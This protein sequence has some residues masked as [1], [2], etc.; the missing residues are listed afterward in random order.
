M[1][2]LTHLN[3][4]QNE[5]Q[6]AVLH[7][8][9]VAPENPVVG[10]VYFNTEDKQA[11]IYQ[12]TGWENLGLSNELLAKL[13]GIEAGADKV[14]YGTLPTANAENAGKVIIYTGTE[15]ETHKPGLVYICEE[16]D[17]A[18]AWVEATPTIVGGD[19]DTATVTVENGTVSV[20]VKVVR[21]ENNALTVK[22]LDD[23]TTTLY[24]EATEFGEATESEPGMMSAEDKAKLDEIEEKAQVNVLEGVK[25][26]GTALT[27]D[28]EKNVDV[29]IEAKD[30]S[31]EIA[32]AE[33]KVT[34]GV[35]VSKAE[36]NVLTLAEDGLSVI[37]PD[38]P[39][40]S[41]VKAETAEAGYIATYHL[42]K[43][44]ENIGASINIPKDFLVK[45]ADL[46]EVTVEGQP[47]AEAK[48]GDKYIDFVVNVKAG[49]EEAASHIYL[50]VN[51]LVDV[52]TAGNGIEISDANVVSAKV[53]AENG[54]SV[55]ENGIKL[56]M[57]SADAA[58]AMSKEH[59]A[60]LEAIEAQAQV[61]KLE[62][63]QFNGADLAIDENKKVNVV[64][65]EA[66]EEAAGF[67]SATDKA[68]LNK[69]ADEAE[70]NVLEGVKLNNV[71]IEIDAD[72]K[73]NI[74][75][76]EAT[77]AKAGFMSAEDKAKLNKI[78]DEAQVNVVEKVSF[79]G[80]IAE[81]D[82]KEAKIVVDNATTTAAGLMSAEDK[83]ALAGKQ[84][85]LTGE[86]YIEITEDNKVKANIPTASETAL[87]LIKIGEGLAID[88]NGLVTV[89]GA[90]EA[91]SVAWEN[92]K[93]KP[94]SLGT[95][96]VGGTH[97]KIT[98][99]ENGLVVK[100]EDLTAADIPDLSD[101]Y[102]N[103]DQ[104]G[105]AN[106]VATLDANAKI[107]LAQIPDTLLG[108]VRYGGTFDPATGVCTLVD[109]KILGED[110]QEYTGLTITAD[111]AANFR[112]YYFLATGSA[113][114]IGIE[115]LVGDWCISNGTAGW[116]KIDNTDA[117]MGVKGDKESTYRIGQV[118]ITAANVGAVEANEAIEAGT[119]VKVTVDEK[120]LVTAGEETLTMADISDI[121]DLGTT[122]VALN[123]G[124][125][126][127]NKAVV[128]DA[129]GHVTTV[130]RKFVTT[131][132]NGTDTTYVINHSMVTKDIIV[133]I[134][135]ATTFEVVYANIV[136][137]D[138]NNITVKFE[139]APA[140]NAYRVIVI[141]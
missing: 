88:E 66:T 36:E 82:A 105:V 114:L 117:V 106:G 47:Y 86:G 121:A 83:V 29:K 24:V 68:K 110:G 107:N 141:A 73:A 48:V 99:D 33:G 41:V 8:L 72:K 4:S 101:T 134:S 25:V 78:A 80:V 21:T 89:T 45:S 64:I 118:N 30:N 90:A 60:K 15:T 135:D 35:K 39:E 103:V 81:I 62:G 96:I 116:A 74:V 59:Y 109:G 113:T 115:F 128:T 63:V 91:S 56:A 137:T 46:A 3:L 13:N 2:I 34:V 84:D 98:Y 127:A 27:I 120:G 51:D 93:N 5:L 125:G 57:A 16:K 11:Y 14:L 69:I 49:A 97:T 12:E 43:D 140:A 94:S 123:Q 75:I 126:N 131:I 40:Y 17:G 124:S 54:L 31:T 58:G 38:V 28:A 119:F 92:V 133:Q 9:T 67:M 52:Y 18:Y 111:N 77:E 100:G 55:D 104:K 79:N 130:A 32:T 42:T 61:N 71:E 138:E 23:G 53:V 85:K 102:V 1:N 22:T 50:P 37:L 136:I 112:G 76:D 19:T 20:D 108:N 87:G 44:G 6:N 95:P 26:N 7:K 65:N 129:E 122:Y 70:V 132:G 10:Q 139:K